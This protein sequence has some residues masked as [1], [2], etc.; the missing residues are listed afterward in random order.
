MGSIEFRVERE[1]CRFL[2]PTRG[3][4][5]VEKTTEIRRD[6]L[7]D[8]SSRILDMGFSP[9]RPDVEGM[10]ERFRSGFNPFAR[11]GREEVTPRFLEELE[12]IP[13]GRLGRGEALVVPNLFP[14][15]RY[16]AVT[17]LSDEDFVPMTG[18]S[19]GLLVD[20]FGADM[21]YLRRVRE[22]D[23][24]GLRHYSINWN[25]MP[26]AG[27]SLV[28]PHHQLIASPFPTN[29]LADVEAGLA[30]YGGR[31]FGDLVATEEG[32][33][34]WV[35]R[36]VG[37]AWLTGFAPMGHV[38][39]LGVFAG[40][41]SLFDLTDEDLRALSRS[42][43]GIFAYLDAEGFA[44]FNFALYGLEGAEGFEVHCRLSPRFLLS[45]ALGTSDINYFE[46]SHSESL[47]FFFPEAAAG[48]L[49]G[50]FE[51]A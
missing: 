8:R 45:N 2:D 44:S 3:F 38:D 41:A 48:S 32:G 21:E 12:G 18:F 20:A 42:L 17:V 40:R 14:Y 22:T 30:R 51:N 47:A 35:G 6:P 24:N 11:E 28:H 49:R 26:L 10:V 36:E 5:P 33:E 9:E 46:I 1:V 15:D 50:H 27:G 23:G 34:R 43:L 19:E 39:V 7:T 13:G 29:Y 25:Y 37:I 16:S 4:E 31:Y